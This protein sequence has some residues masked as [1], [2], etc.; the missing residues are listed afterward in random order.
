MIFLRN[1]CHPSSSTRICKHRMMQ[2][3]SKNLLKCP[4]L[5]SEVIFHSSSI[6]LFSSQKVFHEHVQSL[7]SFIRA[8]E[9]TSVR[10]LQMDLTEINTAAL[11]SSH[12]L[13]VIR[14]RDEHH[15]RKTKHNKLSGE[16]QRWLIILGVFIFSPDQGCMRT[17]QPT[18]QNQKCPV[19]ADMFVCKM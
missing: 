12:I 8:A 6:L 2:A 13:A 17:S 7:I 16:T 4:I 19:L 14:Q 9:L 5:T 3:C 18:E 15:Y 11:H 1:S 10:Y